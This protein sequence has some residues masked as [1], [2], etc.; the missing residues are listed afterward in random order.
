MNIKS[1]LWLIPFF[2]FFI[3]YYTTQRL[4]SPHSVA[5]PHLVGMHLQPALITLTPLQLNAR[6]VTQQESSDVAPGIIIAQSPAPQQ[7]VKPHQSVFLTVTQQPHAVY[8][9]SFIGLT[10]EEIQKKALEQNIR[11]KFHALKQTHYPV[12]TCCAQTPAPGKETDQR[13][14]TVYIA[15]EDKDLRLFPSLK[16]MLIHDALEFLKTYHKTAQVFH[17]HPIPYD[18]TCTSCVIV[19]QK[20]LA[21]SCIDTHKGLIVQVVVEQ[22]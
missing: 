20:P 22:K 6:I 10:K 17:A 19:D 18:H 21:G 13:L 9:P 8:A 3:G 12:G 11:L 4:F 1:A 7:K 14:V 16:G 5:M 2:C 15:T